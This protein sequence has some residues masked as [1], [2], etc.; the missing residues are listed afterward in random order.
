MLLLMWIAFKTSEITVSPQVGLIAGFIL[1]I[2]FCLFY[3]NT[4]NISLHFKTI[5]TVVTGSAL[6]LAVSMLCEALEKAELKKGQDVTH[7]ANENYIEVESYKLVLFAIIQIIALAGY[8]SFLNTNMYGAG[9]AAKIY[10]YRSRTADFG[11]AIIVP[12]ALSFLR[13][14]SSAAGYTLSLIF[15]FNY[16]NKN[17]R[18]RLL[19]AINIIL[20]VLLEGILGARGGIMNFVISIFTEILI[21]RYISLNKTVTLKT[22][23]KVLIAAAGIIIG[24][25]IIGML[26]GRPDLGP[27]YE[28]AVYIG[29]PLKNLDTF[30]RNPVNYSSHHV[31]TFYRLLSDFSGFF[32]PIINIELQRFPSTWQFINGK[33]LGNVYTT[34][35]TFW[36]DLSGWGIP[37][38]T[39]LMALIFRVLYRNMMAVRVVGSTKGILSIVMYVYFY[40]TI[41]FAFF[42]NRFYSQFFSFYTLKFVIATVTVSFFITQMRFSIN[43]KVLR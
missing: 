33:T 4:W 21:V 8:I 28:I 26:M 20:S 23:A 10:N 17:L 1:Q 11:E 31:S 7:Y 39:I 9:L 29:A 16:M 27:W 38:Y 37:F 32:E 3:V 36:Y 24:L 18:H 42:G 6:F 41:V 30:L 40:S 22:L 35:A 19:F 2:L 5:F 14:I 43:G 15:V 12:R 13:L 25:P 34:Y